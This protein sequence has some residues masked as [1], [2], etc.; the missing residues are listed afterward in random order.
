M[1]AGGSV[2]A[3]ITPGNVFEPVW[4]PDSRSVAYS[5]DGVFIVD[6]DGGIRRLTDHDPFETTTCLVLSPAGDQLAYETGEE[7]FVVNTDGT[8]RT[9]LDP[10]GECPT[11]SPG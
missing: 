10:S 1:D 8:G 6:V 4:L 7:V 11:W 3:E 2:L 9:R 5:A